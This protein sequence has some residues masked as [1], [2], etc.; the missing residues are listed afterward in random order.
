FYFINRKGGND[1]LLGILDRAAAANDV[2]IIL[3]SVPTDLLAMSKFLFIVFAMF[4]VYSKLDEFTK[5]YSDGSV[6]EKPIG[7]AVKKLVLSGVATATSVTR[8]AKGSARKA[9]GGRPAK[10]GREES[11]ET[12][13]EETSEVRSE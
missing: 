13:V 10:E 1:T 7:D 4:Y 5:N 11:E 6:G 8:E 3:D 9:A 12:A 2:K